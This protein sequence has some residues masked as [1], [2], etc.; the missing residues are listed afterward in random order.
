M[1][2]SG[3]TN[4]SH[5]PKNAC[6]NYQTSSFASFTYLKFAAA[7]HSVYQLLPRYHT[8]C[9]SKNGSYKPIKEQVTAV[10]AIFWI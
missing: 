7:R 9:T 5:Q 6:F 4:K 3:N 10:E 8:Y 1:L 2:H